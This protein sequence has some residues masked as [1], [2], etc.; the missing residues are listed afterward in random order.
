MIK[1]DRTVLVADVITL[2]ITLRRIVHKPKEFEEFLVRNLVGLKGKLHDLNVASIAVDHIKPGGIG[3]R[4]AHESRSSVHDTWHLAKGRFNTPKTACAEGCELRSSVVHASS[5]PNLTLDDRSGRG[6]TTDEYQ[7][8][9]GATMAVSKQTREIRKLLA[10]L[11]DRLGDLGEEASSELMEG[12][13]EWISDIKD[14]ASR[15]WE[16]GR[17]KGQRAVANLQEKGKKADEYVHENPWQVVAGAAALGAVV[18]FLFSS[19]K[20]D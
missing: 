4:S 13:E 1:D 11:S 10:E 7:Y 14:K 2:P 15:A 17:E 9:K 19:R 3:H 5:V 12:S 20:R 16:M 18:G 6:D 8:M